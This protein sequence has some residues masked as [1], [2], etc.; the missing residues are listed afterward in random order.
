M[1]CVCEQS[2]AVRSGVRGILAGPPNKQGY[3]VMEKCDACNRFSSDEAAGLWYALVKGGTSRYGKR[4][5]VIWCP[6]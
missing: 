4:T 1:L 5:R 2:G 6:K 3:R